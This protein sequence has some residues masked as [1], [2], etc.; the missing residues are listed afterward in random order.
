MT[1]LLNPK[2]SKKAISI[3]KM[4]LVLYLDHGMFYPVV[5]SYISFSKSAFRGEV[6][7]SEIE[8]S[9]KKQWLVHP[10]RGRREVSLHY[11][12]STFPEYSSAPETLD[13]VS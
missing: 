11:F 3:K 2:P 4:V 5:L 12:L 9:R 1:G 6:S 13:L 10:Y 7:S 8:E